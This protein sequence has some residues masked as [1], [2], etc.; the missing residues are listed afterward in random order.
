MHRIARLNTL[1]LDLRSNAH[2]MPFYASRVNNDI[3]RS[4]GQYGFLTVLLFLQKSD[5]AVEIFT[6]IVRNFTFQWKS[7]LSFKSRKREQIF[8]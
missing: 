2:L 5:G 1:S 3:Y 7:L 6:V 4:V 8:R